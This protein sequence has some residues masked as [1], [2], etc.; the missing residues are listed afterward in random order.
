MRLFF[1]DYLERAND[2][3]G[4]ADGFAF[5]APAAFFGLDDSDNVSL[6]NKSFAATNGQAKTASIALFSFNYRHLNHFSIP[7]A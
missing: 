5:E 4:R 7:F 3:S 6:K 1:D 2:G